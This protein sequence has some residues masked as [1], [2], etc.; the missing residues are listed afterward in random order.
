MESNTFHIQEGTQQHPG[1]VETPIP[2]EKNDVLSDSQGLEITFENRKAHLCIAS[3]SQ[4]MHL[5][6]L[7]C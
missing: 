7:E 3:S 5:W 6:L 1:L 2:L 4:I